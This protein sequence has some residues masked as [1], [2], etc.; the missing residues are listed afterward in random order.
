MFLYI[1]PSKLFGVFCLTIRQ[2]TPKVLITLSIKFNDVLTH[3]VKH[4]DVICRNMC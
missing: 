3:F 2:I 1:H 4:G